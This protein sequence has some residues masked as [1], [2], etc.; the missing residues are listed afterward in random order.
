V[1]LDGEHA[2]RHLA[3]QAAVVDRAH[4]QVV[5][6]IF[7]SR[8]AHLGRAEGAAAQCL[9]EVRIAC[10]LHLVGHGAGHRCK[11]E[12]EEVGVVHGGRQ[13][14]EVGR[15]QQC[16][17]RAHPAI[18]RHDHAVA[19]VQQ[20]RSRGRGGEQWLHRERA[21]GH[22]RERALVLRQGDGE[23][24]AA[25]AGRC[26][27]RAHLEAPRAVAA[28]GHGGFHAAAAQFQHGLGI[29]RAAAPPQLLQLQ[30]SV[31][32]HADQRAVGQAYGDERVRRHLQARA[33]IQGLAGLQRRGAG[34]GRGRGA[35]L[36]V[37]EIH[38]G[39]TRGQQLGRDAQHRAW[40]QPAGIGHM[41]V[42]LQLRPQPRGVQV[43][44]G[45]GLQRVTRPH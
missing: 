21:C 42:G 38:L 15:R 16:A 25:H 9:G 33:L 20:R 14:G 8:Q 5:A 12:G 26:L 4:R 44:F 18:G 3:W 39:G 34:A 35:R 32:L 19:C 11:C 29:A 37:H 27:G 30:V 2:L 6:T 40:P 1:R 13:A 28:G 23:A 24:R 22:G 41:V 45:Q 31:R 43:V 7:E 17:R 10:D 36:S